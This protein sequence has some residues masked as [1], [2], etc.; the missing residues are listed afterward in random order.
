MASSIDPEMPGSA[1]AKMTTVPPDT[2]GALSAIAM[3]KI[4]IWDPLKH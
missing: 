2:P 1:M 4:M 3:P